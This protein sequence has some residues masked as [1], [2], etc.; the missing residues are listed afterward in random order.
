VKEAARYVRR[1]PAA[2]VARNGRRQRRLRQLQ[3]EVDQVVGELVCQL[4]EDAG[5][6]NAAED[7]VLDDLLE[8][9]SAEEDCAGDNQVAL[10]LAALQQ[11]NAALDYL[12][13]QDDHLCV[14]RGVDSNGEAYPLS[15]PSRPGDKPSILPG[16][17]S[18]LL[19][20]S[21]T[22]TASVWVGYLSCSCSCS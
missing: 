2:K 14:L 21:A 7:G 18:R 17:Q 3:G 5:S 1:L 13:E 11:T 10:H 16:G 15:A 20:Y 19:L 9:L 8:E 6:E 4:E 22:A 12:Q